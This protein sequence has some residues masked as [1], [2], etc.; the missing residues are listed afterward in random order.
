MENPL[1]IPARTYYDTLEDYID[2]INDFDYS[3]LSFDAFKAILNSHIEPQHKEQCILWYNSFDQTLHHREPEWN[4]PVKRSRDNRYVIDTD[5]EA[6]RKAEEKYA[7]ETHIFNEGLSSK[8]N[9]Q[10]PLTM[11]QRTEKAI[12]YRKM[13]HPEE[14]A[15]NEAALK[16]LAM[17]ETSF[18]KRMLGRGGKTR[19]KRILK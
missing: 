11:K 7:I 18:W 5:A 13:H 9:D 6:K 16:E 1:R 12:E 8:G 19:R 3:S 2:K 15:R 17:K 10:R 14:H 4:V